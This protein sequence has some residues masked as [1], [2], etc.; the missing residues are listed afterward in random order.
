L[1]YLTFF[2]EKHNSNI[3]FIVGHY[4]CGGNPVDDETHK[5]QIIISVKKV[6]SLIP[7]VRIIGLW[8]SNEFVVAK[9]TEK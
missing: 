4:D 8:V 9:V 1:N 6:K 3:I 7:S 5:K 2:L